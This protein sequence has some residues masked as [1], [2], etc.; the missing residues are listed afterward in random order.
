MQRQK[1]EYLRRFETVD[2]S[3]TDEEREDAWAGDKEAE[4]GKV[5]AAGKYKGTRLVSTACKSS[6]CR[7]E[8]EHD[9]MDNGVDFERIRRDVGG[10]FYLEHFEA[11]G[12]TKARTTTKRTRSTT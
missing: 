10:N 2:R 9:T 12:S 4:L 3:F 8:A 5:F 1:A 6:F 7:M 11:T